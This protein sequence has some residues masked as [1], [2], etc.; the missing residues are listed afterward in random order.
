MIMAGHFGAGLTD[1]Y[2]SPTRNPLGTPARSSTG[3]PHQVRA[4]ITGEPS[5]R[6]NAFD[7]DL[8]P[9]NLPDLADQLFGLLGGVEDPGS[10]IWRQR[11]ADRTWRRRDD[12]PGRVERSLLTASPPL[13]QIIATSA[14]GFEAVCHHEAA[15]A[16]RVILR[17]TRATRHIDSFSVINWNSCT[18]R[19]LLALLES[20]S[21]PA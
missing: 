1:S 5:R 14:D 17:R 9:E 6:L 12:H 20:P 21:A 19:I 3:A 10:P 15:I 13:Q 2:G 8:E 18:P 16:D 4:Y 7:R 11:C